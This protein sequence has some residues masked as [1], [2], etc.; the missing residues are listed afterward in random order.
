M[1]P[2]PPLDHLPSFKGDE[3]VQ[4]WLDPWGLRFL[5]T[6][7]TQIYTEF[8]IEQIEP[9]GV[10]WP[11]E[12][13]SPVKSPL[14]VQRLL[15]QKVASFG[16]SDLCLTFDFAHGAKLLVFSEIGQYESGHITTSPGM[17]DAFNVF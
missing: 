8:R 5:F 12:C 10:V 13:Q 4:I 3:I 2:F 11:Y 7:K 15:H 9:D 16:R 14:I 1:Q 6:S 17:F